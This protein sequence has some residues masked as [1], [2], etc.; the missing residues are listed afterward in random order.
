MGMKILVADD[1]KIVRDGLRTLLEKEYHVDGLFEAENG[2]E[3]IKIVEEEEPDLAIIDI[4]MP[5]M[6]GLEACRKISQDYP[7]TRILVLS[8]HKER[9]FVSD[10]LSAGALGYLLKE[11]AFEELSTAI[12]KVMNGQIYLSQNITGI[13]VEDYIRHLNDN[14]EEDK[15]DDLTSREREVLQLLAEG[16]STKE[17]ADLLYLSRKTIETYRQRLKEKLQVDSIAELTKYAIRE[18]YTS[19]E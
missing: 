13:V 8:M 18:G 11:C 16:N 14:G 2:R 10:V 17:I 6:N 7:D 5:M 19:L 4:S 9:H 12:R 3:A 1:H 15:D